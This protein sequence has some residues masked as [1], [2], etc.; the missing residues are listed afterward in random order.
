MLFSRASKSDKLNL[1]FDLSRLGPSVGVDL[2]V[3]A[4]TATATAER[5]RGRMEV[6]RNSVKS[7]K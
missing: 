4:A 5:K 3:C 1:Q 7:F 2:F 6:K